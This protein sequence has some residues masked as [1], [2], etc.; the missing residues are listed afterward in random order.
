MTAEHDEQ[1]PLIDLFGPRVNILN[2]IILVT[3]TFH[4]KIVV[5]QSL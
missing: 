5:E 3:S 2:Q 1:R 4:V